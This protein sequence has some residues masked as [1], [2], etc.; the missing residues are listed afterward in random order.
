MLF[1][2][3]GM[4][5][6]PTINKHFIKQNSDLLEFCMDSFFWICDAL[7]FSYFIKLLWF[8]NTMGQWLSFFFFLCV[9]VISVI[10]KPLSPSFYIL[11]PCLFN[12]YAAYIILN[13]KLNESSTGIK[14]ARRNIDNLRNTDDTMLMAE[15]EEELRN[16]LMRVKEKSEKADLKL[17]IKKNL[18]SWHPVPSFHGK[19]KGK[20]WKQWQILFSWAPKPLQMVTAAMKLKDAWP[21]EGKLWQT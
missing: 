4:C 16:L 21:L 3:P 17:S 14:I 20:K 6:I 1:G 12:L 15:S 10:H 18:R 19:Q 5:C 8:Y 11:S 13:A 2:L 7:R 9:C